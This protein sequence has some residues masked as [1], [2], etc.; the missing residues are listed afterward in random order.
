MV[1]ATDDGS[2]C[3]ACARHQT[4]RPVAAFSEPEPMKPAYSYTCEH[5][6]TVRTCDRPSHVRQFC[7]R[8]CRTKAQMQRQRQQK[9]W[10]EFQI[11]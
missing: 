8:S 5:C 1:F 6:G 7:S 2:I 4:A 11:A 9:R 10:R 3:L